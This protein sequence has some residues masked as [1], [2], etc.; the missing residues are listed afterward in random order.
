MIVES[1]EMVVTMERPVN[2]FPQQSNQVTATA[3]THTITEE[4]LEAVFFVW[5]VQKLYY[6]AS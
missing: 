2:T 6:E 3:D 4:L 1:E 5:S